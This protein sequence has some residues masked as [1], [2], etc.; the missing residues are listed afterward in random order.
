MCYEF[1]DIV[2]NSFECAMTSFKY[3]TNSLMCATN[4]LIYV[5]NSTIFATNQSIRATNSTKC[6]PT[7]KLKHADDTLIMIFTECVLT[8]HFFSSFHTLRHELYKCARTHK[9]KRTYH[10]LMMTHLRN[11]CSYQKL[12]VFGP[13]TDMCMSEWWS[14]YESS[15]TCE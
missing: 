7:H 11:L 6:A 15:H 12:S 1:L 4:S 2:T 14:C 10:A 9:L 3:A 13:R 5:T 8:P